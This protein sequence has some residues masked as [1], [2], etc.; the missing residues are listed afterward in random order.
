MKSM[1]Q[2]KLKMN[3]KMLI[4]NNSRMLLLILILALAAVNFSGCSLPFFSPEVYV[5][6]GQKVEIA[7]P[8]KFKGWVK[9]KDKETGKITRAKYTIKA[10]SGWLM[11]RPK[12]AENE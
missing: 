1:M 6:P 11:G 12:M 2:L 4:L 5:A 8:V 3:I 10:Q 7:E 9:V